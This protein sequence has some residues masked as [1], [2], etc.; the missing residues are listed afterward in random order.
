MA[1]ISFLSVDGV[2]EGEVRAYVA[3]VLDSV[4]W[5]KKRA[6]QIL[7]IGRGT[8]YRKIEEYGLEP[9]GYSNEPTRIAATDSPVRRL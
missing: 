2:S 4:A 5:N 8:L 7:E 9:G 1:D 3:R 6:A